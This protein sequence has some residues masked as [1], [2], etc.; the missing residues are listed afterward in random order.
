MSA[1]NKERA[2]VLYRYPYYYLLD[3]KFDH[4]CGKNLGMYL[5]YLY[6]PALFPFLLD[7]CE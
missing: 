4:A 2:F 3:Q 7:L 1:K 6:E 5:L